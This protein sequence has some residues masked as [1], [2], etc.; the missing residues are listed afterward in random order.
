[1]LETAE[2]RPEEAAPGTSARLI[3]QTNRRLITKPKQENRKRNTDPK[4]DGLIYNK[5][6][7]VI[8]LVTYFIFLSFFIICDIVKVSDLEA[9]GRDKRLMTI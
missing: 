6:F 9:R 7:F 8:D 2:T 4:K 3:R 5:V 1:V